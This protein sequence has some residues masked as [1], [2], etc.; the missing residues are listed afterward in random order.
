MNYQNVY[1]YVK[2]ISQ[3]I[4]LSVKFVHQ[5]K[6]WLNLTNPDHGLVCWSLPFNSSF[7]F[8]PN[9]NRTWTIPIIFYQQDKADSDM[10]QNDQEKMQGSIKTVAITDQAAA[11]FVRLFESND[12]ND[13]LSFASSLL[14][15]TTGTTDIAIRDTAQLLSGTFVTLTVQFADNFDYCCL[16]TT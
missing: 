9:F 11:R 16:P 3:N 8:D 10:D 14:T 12:I 2:D 13:E 4:G 5:N 7:N 1:D 15:V 6:E